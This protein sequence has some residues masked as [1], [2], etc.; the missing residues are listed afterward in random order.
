MPPLRKRTCLMALLALLV[1]PTLSGCGNSEPTLAVAVAKS[2]VLGPLTDQ[3]KQEDDEA[4]AK[5]LRE[6]APQTREEHQEAREHEEQAAIETAPEPEGE[7]E[8]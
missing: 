8:G 2:G 4:E 6:H 5:E 1:V 3:L 7:G